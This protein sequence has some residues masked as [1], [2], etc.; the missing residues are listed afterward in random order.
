MT[1][2]TD[3]DVFLAFGRT[4][5][6]KWADL[7][8]TNVQGSIDARMMWAREQAY[9]ELNSRL[10]SSRYHFPLSGTTFPAI[11]VRMEAYLAGVLLYESRGV[12]DVGDDGKAQHAL[13][14]HRKR[15]DEFVCDI[16][17]KRIELLDAELSADA[18]ALGEITTTMLMVSF[19][20]PSPNRSIP[21]LE[22][23]MIDIPLDTNSS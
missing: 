15:V 12:T 3:N 22:D 5:V 18:E 1:Y 11:L 9:D 8:N 13:M 4:N 2:C 21:R 16:H 17:A 14:W 10:A 19:D 20:D 6:R 7:D 23:N